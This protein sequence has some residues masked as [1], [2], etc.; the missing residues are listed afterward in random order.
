MSQQYKATRDKRQEQKFKVQPSSSSKYS[1][2]S[3][4][5]SLPYM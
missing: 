5:L 1:I 4:P 2:V 3:S